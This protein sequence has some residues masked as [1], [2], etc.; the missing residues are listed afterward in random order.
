MGQTGR[1]CGSNKPT[2]ISHS[3]RPIA[4]IMGNLYNEILRDRYQQWVR[5]KCVRI[6]GTQWIGK[7]CAYTMIAF[8]YINMWCLYQKNVFQKNT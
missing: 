8:V 5:S 2:S 4:C 6:K 1:H 7:N 3:S